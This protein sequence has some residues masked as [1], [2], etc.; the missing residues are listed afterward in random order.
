ME[1]VGIMLYSLAGLVAAPI[2]CV[3][4]AKVVRRAPQL[5][6]VLWYGAIAGLS[7]FACELALVAEF[8]SVG[9]HRLLGPAYTVAHALLTLSAAPALAGALLL[10][11][12]NLSRWWA[13]VAVACW[14]VGV[15]AIF[16]YYS[17]MEALE[18]VDAA[19]RPYG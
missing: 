16:Y 7:L 1:T 8:G 2:F 17:V 15:A 13:A 9:S 18:A 11:R 5:A 12:R 14:L 19:G 6:N 3:L 10:G 4:L